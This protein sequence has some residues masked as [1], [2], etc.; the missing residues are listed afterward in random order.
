M[1]HKDYAVQEVQ[2]RA[3]IHCENHVTQIT[4]KK[5]S[6]TEKLTILVPQVDASTQRTTKHLNL[7][8]AVQKP[9]GRGKDN[10]IPSLRNATERTI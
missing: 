5:P 4:P 9:T 3:H 7:V 10:T 1:P 6:G 8:C 2:H